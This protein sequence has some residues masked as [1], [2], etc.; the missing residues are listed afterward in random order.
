VG[1]VKPWWALWQQNQQWQ[2]NLA[3]RASHKTLDIPDEMQISS[4]KSGIGPLG[5]I[6]VALAA[7]LPSALIAWSLLKKPEPT[8]PKVETP[9]FKYR[10]RF[11]YRDGKPFHE[12]RDKDG[13]LIEETK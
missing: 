4:T 5:L 11:G 10:I 13:K 7:G 3:R 9:T 1:D 8:P 12:V 2:D 6:G